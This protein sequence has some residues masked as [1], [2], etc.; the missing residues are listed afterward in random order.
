RG[1]VP[2]VAPGRSL[3]GGLAVR[4]PVGG[5]LAAHVP[6]RR[7][8]GS[9]RV[10]SVLLPAL[11]GGV[12]GSTAGPGERARCGYDPA[13]TVTGR[14]PPHPAPPGRRPPYHPDHG[15]AGCLRGAAALAVRRHCGGPSGHDGRAVHRIP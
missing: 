2:V 4:G 6:G 9:R 3:T 8:T 10:P 15:R 1:V 11:R 5:P 12:G 14:R 7:A 13:T